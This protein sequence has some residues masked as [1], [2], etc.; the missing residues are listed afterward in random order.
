MQTKCKNGRENAFEQVMPE[1]WIKLVYV[2][3]NIYNNKK[4]TPKVCRSVEID[5]LVIQGCSVSFK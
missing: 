5:V 1:K 2:T 3:A 4:R